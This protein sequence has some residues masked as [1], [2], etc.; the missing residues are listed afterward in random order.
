MSHRL[1][2]W[3]RD[4]FFVVRGAVDLELCRA[5]HD[6]AVEIARSADG[7]GLIDGKFVQPEAREN[8][9]ALEPEDR[10]SKI[11]K[12]HRD[13]PVFRRFIESEP[14]LDWAVPMLGPDLDCFLSQFI[15]KNPGAMGQPW[16][17]DSHYFRFDRTPQVG[18]WVAVTQATLENG[19]LHVLPGS[20]TEPRHDHVMDSRP[21]ANLGYL[22]IVDHDMSESVP[23]LMQAGDLL[24]FHSHLMHRSLDN[25]SGGVRAAMV[26]HLAEAG[27]VD[28][29]SS[30][31][32]INDWMPVR[33]RVSTRIEID[34]PLERVSEV[35]LDGSAYGEW[36]PYIVKIDGAI[37]GGTDVVAHTCGEDGQQM[38]V[39]VRVV[40]TGATGMR[41]EGGLPD[42]SQFKGDHFF[43]LE[44]LPDGRTRLHHYEHFTGRLVGE[45]FAERLAP[46]RSNFERM[47]AA[48][49]RCCEAG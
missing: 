3:Q 47:N 14:V 10:V 29:S 45:I 49:K 36:N 12:L 21:G 35:L 4:G 39:E 11:F 48:L 8:P 7:G 40:S 34:A 23:V 5:M 9:A 2:D 20:H 41:W 28:Q 42:R 16:H 13:E 17:Q 24:V 19:C 33:R 18:I 31:A 25:E 1:E 15:F 38:A 46:I 44:N 43:E 32:G 22:E 27:T 6:R 30:P 37:E 26:Y